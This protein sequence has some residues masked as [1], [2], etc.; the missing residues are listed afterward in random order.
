VYWGRLI[1]PLSSLPQP[2]FEPWH[3][4]AESNLLLSSLLTIC[5]RHQFHTMLDRSS[6]S[7]ATEESRTSYDGRPVTKVKDIVAFYCKACA[8]WYS[9]G[10]ELFHWSVFSQQF[11]PPQGEPGF[12]LTWI[13]FSPSVSDD[14]R[15][16]RRLWNYHSQRGRRFL[17][18]D[19]YP[20]PR[21]TGAV[22]R[23]L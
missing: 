6:G 8:V 22:T 9:G 1:H 14:G 4:T 18:W 19:V 16:S 17:A 21:A 15:I 12:L 10:W 3:D 2:I 5:C 23:A 7:N 20:G 11:F 13:C